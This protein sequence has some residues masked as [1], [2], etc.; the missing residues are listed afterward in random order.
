MCEL[1]SPQVGL[2]SRD[3]EVYRDAEREA[4][5]WLVI[6][7]EGGMFDDNAYICGISLAPS[8][9]RS[10][11]PSFSPSLPFFIYICLSFVSACL[12]AALLLVYEC[13]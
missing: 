6:D 3:F 13:G 7:T 9:A 12:A 8:L 1:A 5:K 4:E 2:F 11:P 10:L